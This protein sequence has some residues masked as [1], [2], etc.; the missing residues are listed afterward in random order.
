MHSETAAVPTEVCRP[1]VA[2][3]GP[4]RCYAHRCVGVSCARST[5]GHGS[6]SAQGAYAVPEDYVGQ[7]VEIVAHEDLVVIRHAGCRDRAPRR[8]WAG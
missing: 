2:C 1:S 3:S 6:A 7:Q 5:F 4:C 8:C